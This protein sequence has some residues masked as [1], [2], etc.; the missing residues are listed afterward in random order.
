DIPTDNLPEKVK[1]RIDSGDLFFAN[2]EEAYDFNGFVY[3]GKRKLPWR[4]RWPQSTHDE[5]L[6][7]LLAL[8]EQRYQLEV[9]SGKHS[10]KGKVRF[11]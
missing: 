11:V 6:A 3:N 4:Y 7:R 2:L 10:K 9:L 8:N 5:I 1:S